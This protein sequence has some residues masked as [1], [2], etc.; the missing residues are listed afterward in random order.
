MQKVL[1]ILVDGMRPDAITE[2][3]LVKELM[4]KASYS[5]QAA[6]V[7]PSVT[8]PC[9]MSLYHSVTPQRHGVLTNTYVPQVRPINGLVDVLKAAGKKSAFFYNWEQLRDL[10]R[11]GNLTYSFFC[12]AHMLGDEK[13]NDLTT[14]AY[15]S[16]LAQYPDTDF[17]FLYL[18]YTDNAGHDYGWMGPEYMHAVENS[19]MNIGRV[20]KAL[21]DDYTVF[22]T[23][24]HG[25]HDRT[26]GYD[27]PEDMTI[28]LFAM[29]PDFAPGASL[30]GATI[31]DI[32]PT[33]VKI[34]GVQPDSDWEGKSLF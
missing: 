15:L 32:A 18:G 23:A 14:D 33:V 25:G 5:L 30:N 27:I 24:D 6:T 2:Q 4:Q 22:I 26:H 34:L 20:L 31:M 7:F 9:H 19:W 8:L 3:P 17:S 10:S 11:P 21:P 28:P 29:G 1:L 12:N 13:C 16:Y